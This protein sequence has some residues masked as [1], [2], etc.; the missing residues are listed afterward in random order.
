[1]KKSYWLLKN[2]I[3]DIFYCYL[4]LT[5]ELLACLYILELGVEIYC[6]T[7]SWQN[8]CDNILFFIV[9]LFFL[10]ILDQDQHLSFHFLQILRKKVDDVVFIR[11]ILNQKFAINFW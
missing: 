11:I 1:M 3:I 10:N 7:F 5:V 8:Y 4:E 9:Y 2:K 6:L